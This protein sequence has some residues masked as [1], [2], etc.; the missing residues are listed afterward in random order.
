MDT[1][2]FLTSLIRFSFVN[3][4]RKRSRSSALI[5]FSVSLTAF[6]KNAPFPEINNESGIYKIIDERSDK[7]GNAYETKSKVQDMIKDLSPFTV[8][9]IGAM[10]LI[11]LLILFNYFMAYRTQRMNKKQSENDGGIVL[12]I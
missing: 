8:M 12:N 9:G 2:C 10:V 5:L 3:Q 11:H 4:P 7:G 6:S 1:S